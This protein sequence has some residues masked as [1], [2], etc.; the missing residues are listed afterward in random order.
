M[1]KII[2]IFVGLVIGLVIGLFVFQPGLPIGV[3]EY[4]RF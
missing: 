2:Y 1:E 3:A 4:N